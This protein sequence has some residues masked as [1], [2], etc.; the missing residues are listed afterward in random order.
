VPDKFNNKYRIPSNRLQGY[1]YGG[2]G[3]YFITICTKNRA[4]YFGNIVSKEKGKEIILSEIGVTAYEYWLNIP[5]H[6]SFIRL[7]GFQVMPDHIHGIII[8]DKTEIPETDRM[9]P[10]Q[11]KF[12]PQS[13]NVGSIIRAYK[14]AVKSYA[15]TN[16]IEFSWQE[17]FYDH[18]VKDEED[19]FRIRRYIRSN[20]DNWEIK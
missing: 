1:D 5:D 11:N 8:I 18:I 10:Y 2:N 19:L 13:K 3:A 16:K 17:R 9:G 14:A 6:F 15:F 12:G 7:D 20:V 4:C